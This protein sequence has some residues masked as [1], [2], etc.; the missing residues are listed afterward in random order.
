MKINAYIQIS[1]ALTSTWAAGG[2][3]AQ[4]AAPGDDAL[5]EVIVTASKSGATDLQKTPLAV[6]A[7]SADQLNRDLA[8]NIKDIA[9]FTPSLRISQVATSAV[10]AIRGIGS[11]N[12]YAGSDPDVTMQIDGVYIARP[13]GQFADFLDVDRVEVLRGPQGTLYGRNAVG[14]TINV[15]S[16]QPTDTFA[17]QEVLTFGNF[18][19]VQTQGYVSGA[20]I[21]GKLQGS[22]SVDY[23]RHNVYE[24]NI[25]AGGQ[26]GLDNA[27]HGGLRVQL[28][29]E[30]SDNVDMT[31]RADWSYL[32]ENL[33]SYDHLVVPYPPDT[34]G[35][36]IV[37]HYSRVAINS[38]QSNLQRGG[39]VSE[40]INFK[41]NDN[42]TFKS[43]SAYRTVNYNFLLDTDD[44]PLNINFGVQSETEKQLSQEFNLNANYSRFSGVAGL[45][46]FYESEDGVNDVVVPGAFAEKVTAPEVWTRSAAAFAQGSFAVTPD[47]RLTLGG[48]YTHE[49]KTIE[50]NYQAYHLSPDL[51]RISN[52]P[53][54]PIQFSTAPT[55]SAFTP[56]FGI[57]WQIAPQAMLYASATRGYKS[58][59][60]N[61]AATS[62]ATASFEPEYIWSY[63]IGAKTEWLDRRLRLNLT[64]FYYDYK[65]L[66]VQSSIAA[67]VSVIGNAA[68]AS[69]KGVEAEITAQVTSAFQ[70]NAVLSWL[71]AH[72]T[73]F[74]NASVPNALKPFL[75][76]SPQYNAAL[77]TYDA[78]GNDL[79][80]A[81][82]F[83]GLLGGQY[84]WQLTSDAS[85][86]V[87]ADVSYQDRDYFD[88]SNSA[89]QSQSAYAVWDA[90]TGYS[91]QSEGWQVELWGKNLANRQYL[92]AMVASSLEPAGVAAP[93][94]TFGIRVSKKW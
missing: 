78:S 38:P 24:D 87:H 71:D 59:G 65:N 83:S 67:G 45:Y 28:R 88:P 19:L 29:Y 42:Y 9:A 69:D 56:K 93:P 3:V 41:I 81:P 33:Q 75:A 61:Y 23:V 11:N 26:S 37:G 20:L 44:T 51:A 15:V 58:G 36:T 77:G 74:S 25:S 49:T 13:S 47:V 34:L 80:Y 18:G 31:T 52:F 55:F 8:L 92:I 22:V 1:L 94:R 60:E 86:F 66:Q 50:A 6:T 64:G 54:F 39:G 72:Y 90:S 10:I 79:N 43:I 35:A 4:S 85:L 76:G 40:D 48:R 84:N 63:E 7:F 46:Y 14:G 70:L 73:A 62:L 57:D 53:G 27:N 32:D 68:T 21:P 2:A 82:H 30:P 91:V 12:V 17:A 16:R 89:L 5:A